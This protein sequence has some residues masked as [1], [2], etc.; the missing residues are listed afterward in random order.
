ME[1]FF[2]RLVVAVIPL[3]ILVM[4][5]VILDSRKTEDL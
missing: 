2:P 5:V 4:L 1:S 3:V